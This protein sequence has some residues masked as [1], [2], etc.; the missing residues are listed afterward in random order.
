MLIP[1][2]PPDLFAALCKNDQKLYV[3]PSLDLVVVRMGEAA[4]DS[5]QALPIV[6]DREIWRI[7]S[8]AVGYNPSISPAQSQNDNYLKITVI[9]NDLLELKE[10]VSFALGSIYDR[11]GNKVTEF[12]DKITEIAALPK[13]LYFVLLRND[14]GLAIKIEKFI[15]LK[16][17]IKEDFVLSFFQK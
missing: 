9:T 14:N 16:F 2:A 13:G 6:L 11:Y 3:V 15:K 10:D 7:L 8:K 5:N 1:E 17:I 12:S 4:G